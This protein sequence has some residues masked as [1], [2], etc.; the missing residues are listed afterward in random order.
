MLLCGCAEGL[1]GWKGG[2]RRDKGR[3]KGMGWLVVRADG[4]MDGWLLFYII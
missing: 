2:M 3:D 4:W 1:G